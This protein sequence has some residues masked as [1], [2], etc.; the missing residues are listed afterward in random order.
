MLER[1]S[2][3]VNGLLGR[4]GAGRSLKVYP[5]DVFIVSFPRSGNT[6]ARFLVANLVHPD[7]DVSFSNIDSLIPEIYQNSE[8]TLNRLKRPRILKSHEYLDVRYLRVIYI[9][10]DPRDLVISSYY[11][12][13]KQKRIDERSNVDDYTQKLL[14]RDFWPRIGSWAEH[15]GGWLGALLGTEGF[16]LLRYEDM[17]QDPKAEVSR[18]AAFLRIEPEPG[19]LARAVERSRFDD[20][21]EMEKRQSEKWSLTRGTR[22]DIPFVRKAASGA[23]KEDLSPESV[24]AIEEK[25]GDLMQFLGYELIIP[26]V[27]NTRAKCSRWACSAM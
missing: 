9:V 17:L 6:W 5:D 1:L 2:P 4:G 12:H 8:R 14:R 10:R 11:Y 27:A 23:W 24:R 26:Q 15:V 18:M 25:W 3:I 21:Q 16:L 20:M 19:R 7:A 22:T 13:L